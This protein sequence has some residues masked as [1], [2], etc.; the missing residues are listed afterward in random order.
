M[1]AYATVTDLIERYDVRLIAELASDDDVAL[2]RADLE[3]DSKVLGALL[4]SSGDID[5]RLRAGKRYTPAKLLSLDANSAA[6]LKDVVCTLAMARLF[7]RRVDKANCELAEL[8]R[9]EAAEYLK[10]LAEGINVFGILDDDTN[11]DAGIPS[12]Q[13]PT[14]AQINDRNFLAAR[15]SMRHLPAVSERNPL[16]RG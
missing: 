1:T 9:K 2:S 5:V 3:S 13:G 6:H 16:T 15:M 11:I 12:L 7:R 4:S 14:S 8:I 10:Q